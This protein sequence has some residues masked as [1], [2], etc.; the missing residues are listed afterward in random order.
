MLL[1]A[2]K[3][4]HPVVMPTLVIQDQVSMPERMA[5][6]E[7]RV[8][9]VEHRLDTIESAKLSEQMVSIQ[10]RI[11]GLLIISVP[12]A[13]FVFIHTLQVVMGI[14]EKFKMQK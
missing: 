11:Q 1:Y 10:D 6:T 4:L 14:R 3:V 9:A 2:P 13:L 12:I 7:Q 5:T 8:T